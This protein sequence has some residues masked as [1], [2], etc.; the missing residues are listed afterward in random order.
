MF[1]DPPSQR[2]GQQYVSAS[3]ALFKLRL[4]RDAVVG[5]S[6]GRRSRGTEVSGRVLPKEHGVHTL[7]STYSFSPHT[8]SGQAVSG[9]AEMSPAL[10][11]TND[12]PC[13]S[14]LLTRFR[15][16]CARCGAWGHRR[17]RH[18]DGGS[19]LTLA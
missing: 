18:W 8:V 12:H 14:S 13:K 9:P 6:L 1:D 11:G 3:V 15:W 19:L 2:A 17:D 16:Q 7:L 5:R 4:L 10:S